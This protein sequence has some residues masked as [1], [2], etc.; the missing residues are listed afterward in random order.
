LIPLDIDIEVSSIFIEASMA[1][2]ATEKWNNGL[3]K[4]PI[5]V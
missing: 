4:L 5:Y 1:W 3:M 2:M